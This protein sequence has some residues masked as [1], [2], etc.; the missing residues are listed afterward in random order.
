[1]SGDL[2]VE[3]TIDEAV[4][5]ALAEV[6][7][8][9]YAVPPDEFV[10]ERAAL[11]RGARDRG[12]RELATAVG[13]L[14]KPTVAAW[15]LNQLVRRRPEAV[16]QL[17]ALGDELRAAQESL[18]GDDLRVLSRQRQSVLAGFVRQVKALA[19][20]LG[21]PASDSVTQQVQETLGAAMADGA[22]GQALRSGRLTTGLSYVGLGEVGAPTTGGQRAR[23]AQR[24]QRDELAEASAASAAAA[25]R[26]S[27]AAEDELTAAAEQLHG[28]EQGRAEAQQAADQAAAA[29]ER[30]RT[31]RPT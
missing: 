20:E 23:P 31:R 3:G 10:A 21:R 13:K 4:D 11:A 2:R 14:P 6:A 9:L 18:A 8:R 29:A 22:A 24:A 15:L 7:D 16:E 17:V 27:A 25:E 5:G 1:M 28:A 19:G 12:E 26:L 30:A